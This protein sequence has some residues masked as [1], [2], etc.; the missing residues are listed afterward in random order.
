MYSWW[1]KFSNELEVIEEHDSNFPPLIHYFLTSSP[2]SLLALPHIHTQEQVI[3]MVLRCLSPEEFGDCNLRIQTVVLP[4]FLIC[5]FTCTFNF[6]IFDS[7]IHSTCLKYVLWTV[8]RSLFYWACCF[9]SFTTFSMYILYF[10]SWLFFLS[11]W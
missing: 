5:L 3:R 6:V 8:F 7:W 1:V 11:L 2:M 4:V 9:R 10:I